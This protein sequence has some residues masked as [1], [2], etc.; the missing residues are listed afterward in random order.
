MEYTVTEEAGNFFISTILKNVEA[1]LATADA[2][3]A[4]EG[5]M[6]LSK[7]PP[8]V[9][10]HLKIVMIKKRD[11][12]SLAGAKSKTKKRKFDKPWSEDLSDKNEG[13]QMTPHTR[14]SAAW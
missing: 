2:V 8:L 10:L 3:A 12:V 6:D 7:P 5:G 9:D 11:I 1:W 4:D 13:V 14:L